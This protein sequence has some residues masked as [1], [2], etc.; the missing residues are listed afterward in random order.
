MPV[1][2]GAAPVS[3]LAPLGGAAVSEPLLR[4]KSSIGIPALMTPA[5]APEPLP[6]APPVAKAVTVAMQP[7]PSEPSRAHTG[8]EGLPIQPGLIIAPVIEV[9]CAAPLRREEAEPLEMSAA[10]RRTSGLGRRR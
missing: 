10:P 6:V 8:E 1:P 5:L 9:V 3:G 4:A 2:F 7:V